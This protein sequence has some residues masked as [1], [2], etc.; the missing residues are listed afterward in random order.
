MA[1]SLAGG[2]RAA[3][4]RHIEPLARTA[5]EGPGPQG[6]EGEGGAGGAT[7]TRL[8]PLASLSRGEAVNFSRLRPAGVLREMAGCDSL[9]LG[10]EE[11]R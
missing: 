8:A 1:A 9:I 2:G 3:H 6:W 7:L 11:Q 5:G 4:G 10:L